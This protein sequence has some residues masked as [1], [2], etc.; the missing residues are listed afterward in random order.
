MIPGRRH[1]RH[2][3]A[4]AGWVF[5]ASAALLRAQALSRQEI[6]GALRYEKRPDPVFSAVA[7]GSLG[8]SIR[9][10][11]ARSY[12][13]FG[14]NMPAIVVRLP[15]VDNSAY[16][17]VRFSEAKPLGSDGRPLPHEI[18]HGIY[19]ADTHSTQI[20][21]VAPG[22]KGLVPLARVRGKVSIR[23]PVSVRTT[24]VRAGSSDAARLGIS[25]DGPYVSYPQGS[26][27]VPDASSVSGTEPLRAYDAAG[28][29]LERYDGL[30]RSEFANGVTRKTVAFWGPVA[31]VRYDVVEGWS[32][33]ELPFDL[34]AAP[35][36]PAGREGLG[37]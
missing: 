15:A 4:A 11:A 14:Y 12:A 24:A 27:G 21:F 29:R 10:T 13:V 17:E 25:I 36:R 26:L 7:A 18:E 22:G 32:E 28:R 20:R 8:K 33:L 37:P 6:E 1:A 35:K 19:D 16:A 34:P 31:S 5:L 2:R 3:V 23:Y 9:V 30:Q